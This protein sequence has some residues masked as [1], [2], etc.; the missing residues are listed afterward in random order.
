LQTERQVA[1]NLPIL[2]LSDP[3]NI[4]NWARGV[5]KSTDSEFQ[6]SSK[7]CKLNERCQQI[8]RFW[9]LMVF[10]ILQTEREVSTN[11]SILSLHGLQNIT[12][13]ARGVNKCTDSELSWFSKYCNLNERCQQ[14]Y[15]FWACMAFKI[16]QTEREVSTNVPILSFRGFQNI[17][18]WARGVNKTTNYEFQ[19]S[20]KYCK[21]SERCQQIYRFWDFMVFKVLKTERE[22]S[23]NL[24]SLS[25]HGL[26]NIA[27]WAR[28]VTKSTDSEFAWS[29]KYCNLSERCQQIY[30]FW[31]CMVFK[32]L[33]TEREMSRNLQ[34]L[35]FH[36]LQNI[37]IWARGVNTST[38]SELAWSSKYCRLSERCQ[39]I[40]RFWA[41]MVFKILQMEREVSTNLPIISLHGLQNIAFWARGVNKTTNSELAWFSKHCKLSERC[42]QIYQFW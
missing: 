38:N 36:G 42:Q 27:N 22:V 4:V 7:Y 2:S 12:N 17:A 32:I 29:S 25:L 37:A 41:C 39:Q 23:T 5:N 18:I 14:I 10:N 13:W 35:N 21:L 9:A 8:Y 20:S 31:A 15:R 11:L 26:Q 16:L 30:Q 19:C 28:G 3:Q 40:Y 34:I 33:Q 1:T 24:P 6:C